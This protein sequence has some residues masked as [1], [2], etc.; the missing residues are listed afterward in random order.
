MYKI[1]S[2]LKHPY[3]AAPD[4]KAKRSHMTTTYQEADFSGIFFETVSVYI[5]QA[6]LKLMILLPQPP[7]GWDYRGEV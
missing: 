7:K 6:D 4:A 1:L 2:D 3:S 5:A